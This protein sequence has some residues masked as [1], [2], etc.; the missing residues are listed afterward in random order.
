MDPRVRLGHMDCL[1]RE[2]EIGNDAEEVTFLYRL[3]DGSSKRSYGLNVARLARLPDAVIALARHHS[4]QFE[5]KLRQEGKLLVSST[6]DDGTT[7][8]VDRNQWWKDKVRAYF[9]KLV[10]VAQATSMPAEELVFVAAE[11]WNRYRSLV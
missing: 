8:K 5:A 1:V 9:E 7:N 10:S 4:V 2:S 6:S 3:C 11:L